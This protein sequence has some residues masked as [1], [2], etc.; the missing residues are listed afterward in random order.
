MSLGFLP[1][2][3]SLHKEVEK[4]ILLGKT[5][6]LLGLCGSCMYNVFEFILTKECRTC[7]IRKGILLITNQKIK[8]A[9]QAAEIMACPATIPGSG[10]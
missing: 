7:A 1:C 5:D 8:K 3:D 10:S 4:W 9:S 6:M 2:L